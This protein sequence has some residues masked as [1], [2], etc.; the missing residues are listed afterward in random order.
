M[1]LA[2]GVAA[3][4]AFAADEGPVLRQ[5][6]EQLAGA[7][8]CEEALPRARRARELAPGDARAALVEGRC[9]LRLGQ[10]RES[11]APLTKAR[12]LDP[13]LTGVSTDLAQAHY[14]L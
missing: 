2:I 5:R 1:A 14:H 7:G 9:L 10:Y 13:S 12:E 6:A 4:P 8:R 3:L 11:L